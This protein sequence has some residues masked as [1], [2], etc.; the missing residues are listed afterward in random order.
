MVMHVCRTG[1][2]GV[3]V[4]V[5]LVVALVGMVVVVRHVGVNRREVRQP[6]RLS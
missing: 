2:G 6:G 4:T 3:V 5:Q 1:G